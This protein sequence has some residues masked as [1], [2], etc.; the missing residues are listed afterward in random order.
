MSEKKFKWFKRTYNELWRQYISI[1]KY[2]YTYTYIAIY[3]TITFEFNPICAD[4][5]VSFWFL[6]LLGQ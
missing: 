2:I 3:K 1:K 4:K 5:D 6:V